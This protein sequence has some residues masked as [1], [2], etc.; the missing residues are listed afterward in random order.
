MTP[1]GASMPANTSAHRRVPAWLW[2]AFVATG[3]GTVGGLLLDPPVMG[4]LVPFIALGA[5]V[6]FTAPLRYSA[7]ALMLSAFV[8]E[9]LE[10]PLGYHY[11]APL[12]PLAR[13]MLVNLNQTTGFPLI[14]VSLLDLLTLLLAIAATARRRDAE[15]VSRTRSVR[16]LNVALLVS[17]LTVVVLDLLGVAQGGNF[18]ESLWQLRHTLLFTVRTLLLLRAFDGSD[19]ELKGLTKGMI[20]AAVVKAL[21]GIWFLYTWIRPYGRDVEFTTSHTDTLLFVPLLALYFNLLVE[22]FSLKVLVDGVWWVPMVVFGMVC[23]DRRLA[24][25]CL[26]LGM[27][28]TL[29]VSPP[30]PFKRLILRATILG[31]PFIP[32]YVLLGWTSQGGS[33]FWAARLARSVIIGDP[34]Q[35]SQ[36]DYRDLENVNVLFTWANHALLPQGFGHKFS[37]LFPLP[38]IS[39]FMPTWQYHPH[40]QYLW[41]MAIGGPI[42]FTL[43]MLPQVVTLYLCARTYRFAQ[44]EQVWV[45]VWCLT[46]IAI[47]ISFFCQMYGDM[48][49]LSYTV[50]WMAALAAALSSKLAVRTGAWPTARLIDGTHS[51][52]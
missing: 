50:S 26:A 37:S 33:F 32:P 7:G 46:G 5:W 2:L 3:A 11:Q 8:F 14:R 19:A 52:R 27:V 30:T 39:N 38:D 12:M 29:V 20:G 24:Y 36:P 43:I 41:F 6:M 44:P 23:N 18:N 34:N 15:Y 28:A 31:A 9:G 40:N 35:G 47:V 17:A 1:A 13:L 25:V 16:P 10:I 51:P 4:A 22:R 21:I 49:T 42:G 45:R 48:G